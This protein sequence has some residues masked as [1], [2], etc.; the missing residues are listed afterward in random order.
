MAAGTFPPGRPRTLLIVDD[1]PVVRQGL[2]ALLETA[3]WVGRI[4][5]AATLAAA[6]K[7]FRAATIDLAIIDIELPDGS[8]LGLITELLHAQPSCRSLVLTLYQDEP[9]IR[10]AI[11]AGARGYLVKDTE[12]ELLVQSLNTVAH[13]G[14]VLGDAILATSANRA[15]ARSADGP[16]SA[17]TS[18]ERDICRLLCE[19]H[20]NREISGRRNIA[21][22]TVRNQISIIFSKVG[23]RD[24]LHLLLLA[25]QHA[26]VLPRTTFGKE[27][28]DGPR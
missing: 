6:R 24:R 22:K 19:G 25:Q 12:P 3:N 23:A 8:G 11:A 13:G 9:T 1:H 4:H 5:E 28:T 15:P 17:L 27:R 7:A 26:F 21:E 16:F 18:T 20:S 10:A 14:S 2:T